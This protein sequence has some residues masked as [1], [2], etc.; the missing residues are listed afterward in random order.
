MATNL[1]PVDWGGDYDNEGHRNF[2]IKFKVLC[3]PG[4][5][6]ASAALAPGLPVQMGCYGTEWNFGTE[7][8]GQGDVDLWCWCSPKRE[9]ERDSTEPVSTFYGRQY[10]HVTFHFSTRP[11][12]MD[13][14]RFGNLPIADPLLEPQK[15]SGGWVKE[16]EEASID[17]FGLPIHNSAWQVITGPQIEFDK[18]KGTVSI[19]Q[20]RLQLELPLLNYLKDS[21]NRYWL[22]GCPPR[23]IKFT[24]GPWE[25]KWFG[26]CSPYYTRQLDFEIR[27]RLMVRQT[28]ITGTSQ[29]SLSQELFV[30]GDWD[31]NIVDQATKVLKG[32]WGT[33]FGSDANDWVLDDVN[34][35]PPNPADPTHFI[36]FKDRQDENTNVVLDGQGK[37]SG[38]VSVILITDAQATVWTDPLLL[39]DINFTTSTPHQ[40]RVGDK[41]KVLGVKPLGFNNYYTADEIPTLTSI[42]TT[43]APGILHPED[44]N[45]YVSGGFLM[46]LKT[47]T[48]PGIN[49]VEKFA[50][51]DY[52]TLLGIPLD[53]QVA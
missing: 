37:P 48:P 35:L 15:I 13:L 44:T 24:P 33:A 52:A 18:S 25:R 12:S 43:L 8:G 32:H 53:F 49:H 14:R 27:M 16:K 9:I 47:A 21:L 42:K 31:R 36:R 26:F 50:D 23:S 10:F 41:F 4:E 51:E 2:W 5:G 11:P 17:R 7:G 28:E 39:N 38:T 30:I 20:N 46:N 34:G 6:P 29:S 40:L 19:S 3:E 45:F 1:G 22:W